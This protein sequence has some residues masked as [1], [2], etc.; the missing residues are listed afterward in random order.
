MSNMGATITQSTY[1]AEVAKQIDNYMDVRMATDSDLTICVGK[2]VA[3][4][5]DSRY[6]GGLITVRK[7][8]TN[9]Y[10]TGEILSIKTDEILR[11][12]LE[13]VTPSFNKDEDKGEDE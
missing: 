3:E 6:N 9:Y 5:I 1:C 2:L 13:Y 12:R 8:E 10:E 11:L 7:T 4:E